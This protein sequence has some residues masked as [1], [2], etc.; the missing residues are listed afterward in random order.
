MNVSGFKIM[1]I[2]LNEGY[3]HMYM[4]KHSFMLKG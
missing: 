1:E 3:T 4:N 2:I